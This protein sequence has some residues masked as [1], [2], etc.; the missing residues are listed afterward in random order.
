[1]KIVRVRTRDMAARHGV[2][3]E[4]GS[5]RLIEGDILG[6]FNVT[7]ERVAKESVQLLAPIEPPNIIAI[8][9]N[10]REH[11]IESKKAIPTKPVMF[12]KPTTALVGTDEAIVL[13]P[14][15]PDE[16]DWEGELA[17]VISKKARNVSEADA[18]E[19]VLGWTCAND[20][21]ARDCQVRYDLQWARAKGFD[22]FC[23]L[24]PCIQTEGNPNN[25]RSATRVAGQTKQ[26]HTTSDM[27]FTIEHLV[28]YISH[29]FT[30][31]PGTVILTGTPAGVGYGHDPQRY[32]REGEVVEVEIEGVGILSN[33][34]RKG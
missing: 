34:V 5:V 1:M 27:I 26:D 29:Q 3:E 18:M 24:G 15:A 21:S 23:P 10:Y 13:P 6:D 11:A 20:V 25:L 19:Y 7:G 28:S 33:P 9:L 22:T 16:V 8:G 31:L 17:L 4:D 14:Q 30:L 2:W 12:I 32:L